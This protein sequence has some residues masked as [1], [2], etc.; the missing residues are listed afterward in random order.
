MRAGEE[1]RA[2]GAEEASL[3]VEDEHRVRRA[4][5]EV[6]LPAGIQGE[7]MGQALQRAIAGEK[8]D[9]ADFQTRVKAAWD[10]E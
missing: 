5:E 6:E 2:P 10:A 9:W 4:L 3:A 7:Q 1:T 8:V